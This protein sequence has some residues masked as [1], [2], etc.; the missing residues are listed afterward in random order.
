[1]VNRSQIVESPKPERRLYDIEIKA[2]TPVVR[3]TLNSKKT[4]VTFRC[5]ETL[6]YESEEKQVRSRE[7]WTT[8]CNLQPRSGGC[9]SWRYVP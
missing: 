4:T 2:C 8:K 5:L 3:Q 7:R 6:P 1:M 9:S